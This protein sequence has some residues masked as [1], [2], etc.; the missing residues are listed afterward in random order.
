MGRMAEAQHLGPRD[1]GPRWK[2]LRAGR[3]PRQLARQPL[4]RFRRAPRPGRQTRADLL[5]GGCSP[6][7]Q[8]AGPAPLQLD[9]LEPDLPA[10]MTSLHDVGPPVLAASRHSCRLFQTSPLEAGSPAVLPAPQI[11]ML[12]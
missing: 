11:N 12:N 1:R 10:S 6:Q 3:Q 4:L 9:S 2:I 5:L 7:F 8:R